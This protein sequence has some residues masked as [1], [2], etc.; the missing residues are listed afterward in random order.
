[1]LVILTMGRV[2]TNTKWAMTKDT[3]KYLTVLSVHQNMALQ[4]QMSGALTNLP[5]DTTLLHALAV[6]VQSLGC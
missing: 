5:G 4:L 3:L 2:V 6:R 1:M